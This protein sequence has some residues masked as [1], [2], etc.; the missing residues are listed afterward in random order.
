[1][2][3]NYAAL[4]SAIADVIKTNGNNEITGALMQQSL[5]AM[6]AS[7]GA[8]YQ[9]VDVAMPSTN[10]GTP[11]QNVMYF[12]A[13]A[14]TYAN[15]DGIRL[16]AGEVCFLC[17]NGSWIKK[18]VGIASAEQ[19]VALSQEIVGLQTTIDEQTQEIDNFEET[20]RDQIENFQP[21]IING[22]VVNAP[23][24]ED[25]TTD[26]NNLLKFANR[27]TLNGMGYFIL[28]RNKTFAEQITLTNTIYE[29]RYDFDLGGG[30]VTIPS[31]S[32]LKFVGGSLN[33]GTII[34][35]NTG[36]IANESETIFGSSLNIGGAWNCACHVGWFGARPTM[37]IADYTVDNAD[38]IQAAMDSAFEIVKFGVGIYNINST[39]VMK[40]AKNLELAGRSF[41]SLGRP[42]P[43]YGYNS[44]VV[45][46]TIITSQLSITLL[47]VAIEN[48]GADKYNNVYAINIVGG[49]WDVSLQKGDNLADCYNSSVIK[50]SAEENTALWYCKLDTDIIGPLYSASRELGF[51]IK[52]NCGIGVEFVQGE[53]SLDQLPGMNYVFSV[54]GNIKGFTYGA[55]NSMPGGGVVTNGDFYAN[56]D[57]CRTFIDFGV[58]MNMG[59]I[60]GIIQPRV[61]FLEN[62][63]ENYPMFIGALNNVYINATIWDVGINATI[64]S[65]GVSYTLYSNRFIANS[66]N[67][68]SVI[69]GDRV[70][71]YMPRNFL[72]DT[73][74][75]NKTRDNFFALHDNLTDNT[76]NRPFISLLNNDLLRGK[77]KTFE[78]EKSGIASTISSNPFSLTKRYQNF[79]TADN[80]GNLTYFIAA[81]DD[82]SI[83]GVVIP[84]L[85]SSETRT[86]KQCKIS[87]YTQSTIDAIKTAHAN[88]NWAYAKTFDNS[89][90]RGHSSGFPCYVYA[91]SYTSIRGIVVELKN[92][93]VPSNGG[94]SFMFE[95][96]F[97]TSQYKHI[98]TSERTEINDEL[99]CWEYAVTKTLHSNAPLFILDNGEEEFCLYTN[100]HPVFFSVASI[101]SANARYKKEGAQFS[102]YDTNNIPR[103]YFYSGR[104]NNVYDVNGNVAGVANIGT[105]AERPTSSVVDGFWYFDTTLGKPIWKKGSGW[106]D[107]TGATV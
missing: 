47:K 6:I 106:V 17:W 40:R 56:F 77:A 14:G 89:I 83:F 13:T 101:L 5:F 67:Y 16:N 85:S 100:K 18:S 98:N 91:P 87:L 2:A 53:T 49:C 23:D 102:V 43:I 99:T 48:I 36:V 96:R 46:G 61:M 21:I 42:Y 3:G 72:G 25:I 66:S 70:V 50:I 57:S 9:F 29:I 35:T 12:A 68:E 26:S 1:M 71:N 24:Q 90:E 81:T 94:F 10:P 74:N 20:V 15:F 4:K 105:T 65:G 75:F 22:D 37:E 55:K 7:L 30:S 63:L 95:G 60:T 103:V 107:A 97:M 78:V 59:R 41:T 38:A 82:I 28:R 80:G 11:D 51:R 64:T 93:Y 8:Y 34:G 92:L 31:G 33:N 39:I 86:F 45:K 79:T 44:S 73:G 19:L 52:D 84:I 88:N 32:I 58:G 62:E 104:R 27:G 76:N 69:I 54:Y